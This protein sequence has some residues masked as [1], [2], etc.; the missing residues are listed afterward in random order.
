MLLV[1]LAQQLCF[2]EGRVASLQ[3]TFSDSTWLVV[4]KSVGSRGGCQGTV[5]WTLGETLMCHCVTHRKYACPEWL[6]CT[7]KFFS[8]SLACRIDLGTL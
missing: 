6:W 7:L 5:H 8:T 3:F 2:M 1:A 4:R